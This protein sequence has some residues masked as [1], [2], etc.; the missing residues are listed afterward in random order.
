M[1]LIP[2]NDVPS[3]SS[4]TD[5]VFQDT[6]TKITLQG[7][8][9]L[10]VDTSSLHLYADGLVI[11]FNYTNEMILKRNAAARERFMVGTTISVCEQQQLIRTCVGML[12]ADLHLH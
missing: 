6:R 3:T 11:Q 12:D 4:S 8:L 9:L 7:S 10:S 2:K 5:P 1:Q